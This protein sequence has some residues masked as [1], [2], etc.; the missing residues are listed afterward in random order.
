MGLRAVRSMAYSISASMEFNVPSTICSTTGSTGVAAAARGRRGCASE[1]MGRA[2]TLRPYFPARGVGKSGDW[3]NNQD[4]VRI[5][6]ELLLREDHGGRAELLDHRGT[7]QLQARS[8]R[9]TIVNRRVAKRSVEID[10]TT[11]VR[12]ICPVRAGKLR[13]LRPFD[14]AKS[15]HAEIHELDLLL[16][17]IVVPE[18]AQ[19]CGMECRDQINEESPIDGPARRSNSDFH[20]LTGIADIGLAYELNACRID[21][22]AFERINRVC[23]QR[24]IEHRDSGKIDCVLVHHLG[25]HVIGA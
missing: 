20:R 18:R 19:M 25:H 22:V 12:G 16:A 4:A 3:T 9:P 2:L 15:R 13:Y 6:G 7:L 21:A 5:D 8:K 14:Q 11:F 23:F 24:R 17:G 10:L 1:E